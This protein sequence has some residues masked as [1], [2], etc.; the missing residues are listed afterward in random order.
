MLKNGKYGGKYGKYGKYGND[1]KY[2]KYGGKYGGSVVAELELAEYVPL[3]L[4]F[5]ARTW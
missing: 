2:G 1:G 5:S 3:P 4:A